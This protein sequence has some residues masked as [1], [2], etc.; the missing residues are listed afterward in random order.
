V[1]DVTVDDVHIIHVKKL[2]VVGHKNINKVLLPCLWG[3][4]KVPGGI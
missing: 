1:H 3:N 2:F 4:S